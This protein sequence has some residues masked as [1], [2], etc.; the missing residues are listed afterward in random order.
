MRNLLPKLLVLA[1]II[2]PVAAHA[3]TL[4]VTL[5]GDSH[6]FVFTLPSQ[7]SFPDQIH[8]VTVSPIQ[9]IGTVDGIGGQTVSSV[10]HYEGCQ[11]TSTR[12]GISFLMGTVKNE[13][14]SI[15]K[16]VSVEGTVP[17]MWCAV[18]SMT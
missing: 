18:P 1:P 11:T 9:T 13:G 14:G 7:F 17:V 15:L 10:C 12:T 4:D 5:T 16:S 8:L 2:L 6:T 3:D